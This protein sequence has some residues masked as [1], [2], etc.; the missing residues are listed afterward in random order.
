VIRLAA[1]TEW[2]DVFERLMRRRP[3][4][5]PVVAS[6]DM[7]SAAGSALVLRRSH[8]RVGRRPSYLAVLLGRRDQLERLVARLDAAAAQAREN[9]SPAIRKQLRAAR[10]AES[11]ASQ[12]LERLEWVIADTAA[13]TLDDVALKI[14]FCAELP[15]DAQPGNWRAPFSVKEQLLR[16]IMADLKRLREKPPA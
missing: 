8:V 16:T 9:P 3:A 6:R 14:R 13:E 12:A 10:R 11:H 15:G 2:S 7:P 5:L 4:A 1:V